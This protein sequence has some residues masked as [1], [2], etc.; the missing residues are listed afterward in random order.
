MRSGQLV[1]IKNLAVGRIFLVEL[2]AIPRGNPS[3]VIIV[4]DGWVIPDPVYFIWGTDLIHRP[5][6]AVLSFASMLLGTACRQQDNDQY[7]CPCSTGCSHCHRRGAYPP[8]L[9]LGRCYR[10]D[11][12]PIP[13]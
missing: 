8:P 9:I 1:Q 3:L 10:P 6:S 7:H 12:R 11:I 4:I 2:L 13:R 5:S